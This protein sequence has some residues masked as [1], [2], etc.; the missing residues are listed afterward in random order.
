MSFA[1]IEAERSPR[2]AIRF[3]YLVDLIKNGARFERL[4]VR[5]NFF[6][7]TGHALNVT[8]RPLMNRHCGTIT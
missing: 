7:Y 3:F 6:A 5:H 2:D 8:I 1:V 4:D